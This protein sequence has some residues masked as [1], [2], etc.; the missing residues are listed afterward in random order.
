[1]T[2]VRRCDGPQGSVT[3]VRKVC[4]LTECDGNSGGVCGEGEGD[5]YQEV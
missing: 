1:M 5:S 2:V 3:G 4:Q